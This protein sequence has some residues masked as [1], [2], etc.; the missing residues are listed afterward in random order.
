MP[1]KRKIHLLCALLFIG[2]S[3]AT[4]ISGIEAGDLG[5][6]VV[7]GIPSAFWGLVHAIAFVQTRK[8]PDAPKNYYTFIFAAVVAQVLLASGI[9]LEL[10][11]M[12]D[13]AK[14]GAIMPAF[15]LGLITSS[16]MYRIEVKIDEPSEKR[17]QS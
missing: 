3:A 10:T 17:K 12:S 14:I 2:L 13:M 7:A 1:T 16:G 4:L 8:A 11:I 15:I 6:F 9:I 5:L